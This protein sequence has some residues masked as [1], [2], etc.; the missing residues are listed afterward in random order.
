MSTAIEY[1]ARLFVERFGSAAEKRAHELAAQLEE[2]GDRIA[3]GDWEECAAAVTRM[4]AEE[5]D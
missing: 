3:A 1:T 4:Q 5:R 2:Q